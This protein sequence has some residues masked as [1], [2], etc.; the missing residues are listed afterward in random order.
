MDEEYHG[1]L[2]DREEREGELFAKKKSRSKSL[3]NNSLVEAKRQTLL[4]LKLQQVQ[5]HQ[6]H[7]QHHQQQQQQHQQL[8]ENQQPRR[9]SS[10]LTLP[11]LQ[12]R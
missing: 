4:K 1:Y 5:Q 10:P 2:D 12:V 9:R 11:L 7:H 3:P 6:Q 8:D